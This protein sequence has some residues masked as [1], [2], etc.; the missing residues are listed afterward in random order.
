MEE[1]GMLRS[2]GSY[3]LQSRYMTSGWARFGLRR[4]TN[5]SL[6]ELKYI[7]AS[8]PNDQW[9]QT[10]ALRHVFTLNSRCKNY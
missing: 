9:S 1:I 4:I 7:F 6:D 10:N 5:G 8:G 2:N 3:W